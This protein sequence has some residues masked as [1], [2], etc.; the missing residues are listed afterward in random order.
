MT[1]NNESKFIDKLYPIEH[2]EEV[3]ID[4]KVNKEKQHTVEDNQM[5]QGYIDLLS[6]YLYIEE[7]YVK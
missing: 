5:N 1:L 6:A 3:K 4:E 2:I 7:K